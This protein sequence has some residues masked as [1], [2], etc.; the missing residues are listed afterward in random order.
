[1][2][3]RSL[4]LFVLFGSGIMYAQ[5]STSVLIRI[6]EN[7]APPSNFSNVFSSN[8]AN[9]QFAYRYSLSEFGAS[10][11]TASQQA[12][13]EQLGNGIRQFLI[14][15]QS[16]YKIDSENTVFGNA[17]YKNGRRKNVQWNE[18]SDYQIIYPY[19]TADSIGGDLSYEEYSFKGGYAKAFRKMTL[20]IAAEYRAL[21]EYRDI[22]PRPK[23]TVSDLKVAAGISGNIGDHYAIGTSFN[24]QKYTQSNNLKFF[25]ELGA[26][27]VYHMTG[28]GVYNNLLTGNKLSSFYDGKGYGANV[29]FFPKDRNG[30]ALSIGYNHFDYEKIMTEFQNLIASGIAEQRFEGEA[31][32]LKKTEEQVW[33]AKI[34][35]SYTD[36]AGTENIFDN[37]TTTSYVKISEYTKYTNEVASVVFSGLYYVPNPE[38][39]W[40]VAPSFN[41]KNTAEK[42]IDPLRTIDIQQ[43]IG[44][45]DFSIS[46]LLAQSLISVSS[47]FE[48]S[49]A[50]DAKMKL[51]DRTKTNQIFEMLDHN[52]AY[53]SAAY[54]KINGTVRWDYKYQADLNFF[55]K[56]DL[57]YY[58]Y[59]KNINNTY[60][61]MS[62]GLTF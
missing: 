53:L 49:W 15:A 18:S 8:P 32:Y 26:P 48:Y 46:K 40:S 24:V 4:F 33:G 51:T 12:N 2:S 11:S 16:Y 61:Q 1:M 47:S 55:I 22:D 9:Q 52:F 6:R 56:A 34:G 35:V 37:Q 20:G 19:V 50:L 30:F 27:A 62:L 58:N 3:F 44:K 54:T 39:S 36:R 31:S 29:Q 43:G 60:G 13:L 14:K 41:L 25:S 28:L 10:Y 5:D 21:L 7:L 45:L 57:D 38:V 17:S 42:Y 23:N 59:S